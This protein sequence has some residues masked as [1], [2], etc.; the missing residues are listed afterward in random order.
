MAYVNQG[1]PSTIPLDVG[2]VP[3]PQ[4]FTVLSRVSQEPSGLSLVC[5]FPVSY[6]ANNKPH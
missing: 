3:P 2:S 4:R 5:L 1:K 6:L